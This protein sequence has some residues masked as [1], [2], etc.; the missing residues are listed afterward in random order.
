MPDVVV[1][2]CDREAAM[3]YLSQIAGLSGKEAG[4][5]SR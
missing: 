3:A 5:G 1:K 2:Q 4:S